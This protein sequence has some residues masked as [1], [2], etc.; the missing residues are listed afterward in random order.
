MVGQ[1]CLAGAWVVDSRIEDVTHWI[2]SVQL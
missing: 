2:K 1:Q